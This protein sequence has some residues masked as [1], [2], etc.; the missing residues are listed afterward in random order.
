MSWSSTAPA[1]WQGRQKLP[2]PQKS[3]ILVKR[4]ASQILS[5]LLDSKIKSV[6]QITFSK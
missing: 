1:E 2:Q 5:V 3:G 6:E 4:E